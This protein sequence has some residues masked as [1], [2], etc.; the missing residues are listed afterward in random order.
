MQPTE[1]PKSDVE[2]ILIVSA[3]TWLLAVGSALPAVAVPSAAIRKKPVAVSFSIFSGD[4][5]L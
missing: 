4:R 1:S 5:F 2:T 3:T